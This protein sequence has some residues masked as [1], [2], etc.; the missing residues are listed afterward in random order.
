MPR[1]YPL[2]RQFTDQ[3]GNKS[4]HDFFVKLVYFTHCFL[5]VVYY[6]STIVH[7][8]TMDPHIG[9]ALDWLH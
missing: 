9:A 7:I 3:L 4:L 2:E 6:K 1:I 5:N 8:S